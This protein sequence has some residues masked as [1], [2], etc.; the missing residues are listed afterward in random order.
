MGHD[1]ASL[2]NDIDYVVLVDGAAVNF[3]EAASATTRAL[4]IGFTLE[5]QMIEIVGTFV[6]M[7]VAD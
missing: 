7:P 1:S 2:T 5:T 4:T 3:G 6:Q